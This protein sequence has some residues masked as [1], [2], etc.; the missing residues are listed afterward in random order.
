MLEKDD[1][2]W[3][4]VWERK[5]R[6]ASG[7]AAYA[8]GDLL[9]ADGFDGAMAQTGTE[10]REHI[11]RP[12]AESLGIGP[13]MNALGWVV[14]LLGAACGDR[15]NASGYTPF[16]RRFRIRIYRIQLNGKLARRSGG[17]RGRR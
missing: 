4:Q 16:E 8:I 10:A 2:D 5:G 9:A 15:G 13:G 6:V 3:L 14:A 7:K 1:S 17:R 11:K 12:I